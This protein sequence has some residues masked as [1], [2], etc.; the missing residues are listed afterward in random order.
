MPTGSQNSNIIPT[1]LNI[2]GNNNGFYI[3]FFKEFDR[4]F[5][6]KFRYVFWACYVSVMNIAA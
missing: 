3:F 2:T 1:C 5:R 4:L 6:R